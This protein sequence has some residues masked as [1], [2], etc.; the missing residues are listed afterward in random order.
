MGNKS[1]LLWPGFYGPE[2]EIKTAF[3]NFSVPKVYHFRFLD[4]LFRLKAPD[5]LVGG[6]GLEPPTK[7]L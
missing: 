4:F 2:R 6:E 3:L 5:L 7:A 1:G